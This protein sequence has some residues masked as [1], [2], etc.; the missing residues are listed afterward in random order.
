MKK[1]F[2]AVTLMLTAVFAMRAITVDEAYAKI[3]ALPGVAVSEMP[4]H[5]VLKDGMDWGKVAMFV[6]VPDA[7]L[8]QVN[9]VLDEIT[10]TVALDKMAVD[11]S[12]GAASNPVKCFTRVDDN[13][14]TVALMTL[15]MPARKTCVVQYCQ[16]GEDIVEKLD[17]K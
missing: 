12:T 15:F 10:D 7:T 13:G 3:I 6:M 2:F 1:L 5:D 9:A 16:G 11:Q 4:E 17:I 8:S 14:R